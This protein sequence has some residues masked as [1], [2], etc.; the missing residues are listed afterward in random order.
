MADVGEKPDFGFIHL[1]LLGNLHLF[2]LMIKY[3]V[4][5]ISHMHDNH[6]NT[7]HSYNEIKKSRSDGVPERRF[8][9]NAN[10]SVLYVLQRVDL[11]IFIL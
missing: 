9:G 10:Q 7:A 1:M 8:G 11:N 3:E 5:F 4:V 2:L 6:S